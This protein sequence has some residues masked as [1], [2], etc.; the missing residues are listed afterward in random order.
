MRK[1]S[2]V[3]CDGQAQERAQENLERNRRW[4]KEKIY[5]SRSGGERTRSGG[6]RIH[7]ELHT[8]T[9]SRSS[10]QER[11][12]HTIRR[13]WSGRGLGKSRTNLRRS[14]AWRGLVRLSIVDASFCSDPYSADIGKTSFW[15]ALKGKMKEGKTFRQGSST[16]N[17]R[18]TTENVCFF[19]P[20][21]RSSEIAKYAAAVRTD[22]EK[23]A[24][25]QS[26]MYRPEVARSAQTKKSTQRCGQTHAYLAIKA[27]TSAQNAAN[28]CSELLD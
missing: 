3:H 8:S 16:V 13:L 25:M 15:H 11:G 14:K 21:G 10:D 7:G 27:S 6:E 1:K 23:I 9:Y 4:F 20:K 2:I 18:L 19:S 22:C 17:C 5:L 26:T 12:E 24:R 28:S